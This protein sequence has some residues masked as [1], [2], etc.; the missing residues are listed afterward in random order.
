MTPKFIGAA[1]Q[2]LL[3]AKKTKKSH[4]DE[5]VEHFKTRMNR[6]NFLQLLRE[7][8][9]RR[10]LEPK[11]IYTAACGLKYS[12]EESPVT[13]KQIEELFHSISFMSHR[14]ASVRVL[15]TVAAEA[16]HSCDDNFSSSQLSNFVHSLKGMKSGVPEVRE[17]VT[18]L[19]SKLEECNENI[20]RNSA[21][22]IISSFEGFSTKYPEIRKLLAVI[23][24]DLERQTD[25]G[26]FNGEELGRMLYGM[27]RMSSDC[28]EVR[29]LAS[30]IVATSGSVDM[31]G[32]ALSKAIYAVESMQGN[33]NEVSTL[34]TF[35]SSRVERVK[36]VLSKEEIQKYIVSLEEKSLKS[37]E[38]IELI[39]S[40]RATLA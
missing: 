20:S 33:S 30:H 5:F 16:L 1:L 13:A 28:D 8:R 17:V 38:H 4:V 31:D 36:L 24:A 3:R 14:V 23:V 19:S 21:S 35:L 6:E 18:V 27:K 34:F 11:H 7:C 10:V 40:L 22:R 26:A 15:L 25:A 37:N 2:Q 29:R 32:H 9:R 12:P 39:S